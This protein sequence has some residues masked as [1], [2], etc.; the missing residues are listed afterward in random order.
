MCVST[1]KKSDYSKIGKMNLAVIF[2]KKCRIC[3]ADILDIEKFVTIFSYVGLEEIIRKHLCINVGILSLVINFFL[4]LLI[5]F[6]FS[7]F[8]MNAIN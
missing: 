3:A 8:N 7:Q 6:F 4:M 2:D 1:V 5:D